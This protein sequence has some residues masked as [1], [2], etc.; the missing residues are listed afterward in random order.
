MEQSYRD[1]YPRGDTVPDIPAHEYGCSSIIGTR[2]SQ[3]DYYGTSAGSDG[4]KLLAVVCD[5]MGGLSGGEL[6]SR[7][8]VETILEKYRGISADTPIPVFFRE[9][10]SETD[11]IISN[12]EESGKR[13]SAGTTLAAVYIKERKLFRV[14]VGDSRIYLIRG[15]EIKSI[16]QEHNYGSLLKQ[17]LSAGAITRQEYEADTQR[18]DALT[19]YIGI[20]SPPF[21]DV[22]SEP[23][24]LMPD[25]ILILCS[26]GLFKSLTDE[27]IMHTALRYKLDPGRAAEELTSQVMAQRRNSQDNTTAV[28]I[29]LNVL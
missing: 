7:T 29:H 25:D 1:F 2:K 26:D 9:C 23:F 12:L 21:I 5:G 27:D 17:R 15:G 4:D 20:G 22:N 16:C 14:S 19:S 18:K 10:V 13:I 3:Q 11:L 6:A 8:T 24:R 28:V